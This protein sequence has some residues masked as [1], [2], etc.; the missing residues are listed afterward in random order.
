[1]MGIRVRAERDSELMEAPYEIYGARNSQNKGFSAQRGQPKSTHIEKLISLIPVPYYL[2]WLLLAAAFLSI[3][4]LVLMLFEKSFRHIDAFLIISAIIA[5]EGTAISW[6]HDRI[7]SFE[8]VLINIVELP[9]AVIIES[10]EKQE[11]EI[12]NDIRMVIFAT[13]FIIFVHISGIDYHAVS[14]NSSI[15]DVLF[16]SGYYF[17]VYLEGA[18]LYILIMTAWSVHKIGKLPL[19]VNALFSDFHAVGVLYSKFTILAASV[20]VMWGFF[21]MIVP[22]QFSSLQM[23]LWFSGFAVLLFAYFILPQ[24]SIHR[25]MTSTKREKIEMFSSQ[26][27]AALDE[28]LETPT[29]ENASYL[30]DM[31][32]VQNQLNQMCEWPFGNYEILHIALIIVIPL[33]VVLLEILFGIIK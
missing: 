22:P 9:K 7:K 30:T 2:G 26:M 5:L 11:A 4:Y 23:I 18:G 16:K 33:I 3:S 28:S 1:M 20:Y 19:K 29:K 10:Y 21:H 6:A 32:S 14:F 12:F 8:D 15:S 13:I 25:M 24:Y 17:A 27:R 31:L